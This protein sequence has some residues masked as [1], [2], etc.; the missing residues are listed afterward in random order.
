M[1]LAQS[2]RR[3][4]PPVVLAGVAFGTWQAAKAADSDNVSVDRVEHAAELGTALLSPRRIPETLQAP[5]ADDAIQPA[6]EAFVQRL[7]DNPSCLV[8]EVDGRVLADVGSNVGLIP[9]SNQKLLTT[10]VALRQFGPDH[11]FTTRVLADG[12]TTD[13]VLEGDLYFVG[14]GDPFLTTAEWRAQYDVR[15]EEDN[16]IPPAYPRNFSS[17]ESLADEIAA[18]GITQITGSVVGDEALFDS[19]RQGPW[20]GRL[21]AQNQSGPLSALAVNEGFASWGQTPRAG[22][23][24]KSENPPLQAADELARLLSERGIAVG[25]TTSGTAPPS[26]SEIAAIESATM[27]QLITDVNSYSSNYGA[28]VLLKHIGVAGGQAG[29]TS[30]GAAAM[31][32]AL[33]ATPGLSTEGLKILDGS[34]LSEQNLMTCDFLNDLLLAAGPNSDFV[35]SLSIGGERGSLAG[36]HVDTSVDGNLFAKT[37]TLNSATALSGVLESPL[38]PDVDLSFSYISN[39]ELIARELPGLQEPFIE[40]LATYPDAPSIDDLDPL[41]PSSS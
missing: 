4:I 17:L 16:L 25:G 29:S 33:D 31:I 6:I 40:Q 8:I 5:V 15:D 18:T 35:R 2:L 26:A 32:A 38:D 39:A 37:G 41:P 34:G 7:G 24:I 19:E 1:S 10:F 12:T 3:W 11:R 36:R 30:G 28:E 9:A 14:G 13:G 27:L 23:R 20:A 21:I 22:D